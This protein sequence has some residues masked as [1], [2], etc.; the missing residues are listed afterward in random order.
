MKLPK[1]TTN[2]V[3]V[4]VTRGRM[5]LARHFEARPAM[6]VCPKDLRIPIVLRG[7]LS[8][9]NSRDDGTSIEFTMDVESFEMGKD[10][11]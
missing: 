4:D 9:Q 11:R 5:E 8:G 2:F 10:K 1:I 7:Y 6:G 3:I